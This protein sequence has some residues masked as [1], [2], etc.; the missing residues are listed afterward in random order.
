M[1]EASTQEQ[2]DIFQIRCHTYLEAD[3]IL[4]LRSDEMT[5]SQ[6]PMGLLEMLAHLKTIFSLRVKVESAIAMCM[7]NIHLLPLQLHRQ[8]NHLHLCHLLWLWLYLGSTAP[9]PSSHSSP[10]NVPPRMHRATT[11]LQLPSFSPQPADFV[12]ISPFC[13]RET[14]NLIIWTHERR[15]LSWGDE[16]R[17]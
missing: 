3:P 8:N 15:S 4:D 6:G 11:T 14:F 17:L 7:L 13:T 9:L 2:Q 16:T 10:W 12:S 5:V 1:R